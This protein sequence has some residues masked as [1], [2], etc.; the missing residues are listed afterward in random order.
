MPSSRLV[1]AT[2]LVASAL[3]LALMVPGGFVETRDFSA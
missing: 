2:L 3:N 1:I